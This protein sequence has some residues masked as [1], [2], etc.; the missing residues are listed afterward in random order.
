MSAS[1]GQLPQTYTQEEVQQILHLAIA[2]QS[3]REELSR[4]Q[5]WEIATELEIDSE[6]LQKAELDWLNGRFLDKKRQEFNTYRRELLKNK[7]TRYAIVNAFLLT[8]DLISGGTLSWSI[9]ILLFWGIG[10]SLDTWKTFQSRGDAYEQA[11]QKWNLKN[12]M[13]QSM[14]TLWN[15]L[16]KVWQTS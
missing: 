11:F 13:K 9:Y 1:E 6:T 8:I 4:E 14:V 15:K 5:L 12:E 10:L 16:K 3:D 7:A 2:Q